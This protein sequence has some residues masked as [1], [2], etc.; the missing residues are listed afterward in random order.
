MFVNLLN[1]EREKFIS[2]GLQLNMNFALKLSVCALDSR[3]I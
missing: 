2:L 3:E 1:D